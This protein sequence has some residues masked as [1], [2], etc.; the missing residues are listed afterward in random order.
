MS[1]ITTLVPKCYIPKCV[2]EYFDSYHLKAKFDKNLSGNN[3]IYVAYRLY[4]TIYDVEVVTYT[5]VKRNLVNVETSVK[6]R[7]RSIT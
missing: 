2:L 4:Y 5:L 1:H 3:V 7:C 6:V